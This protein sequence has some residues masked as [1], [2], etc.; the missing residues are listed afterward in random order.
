M[1]NGTYGG[2]RGR[3]T[4]VGRKLLRFPPTRF[5]CT[6]LNTWG[7]SSGNL[8]NGVCRR[9]PT[10]RNVQKFAKMCRNVQKHAGMCM[11]SV[12]AA[13]LLPYSLTV[14]QITVCF[15]D[16]KAPFISKNVSK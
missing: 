15:S 5:L 2:V 13:P 7:E 3:K 4:K 8:R 11:K 14:L 9:A 6:V 1:P 16:I 10:R 12:R